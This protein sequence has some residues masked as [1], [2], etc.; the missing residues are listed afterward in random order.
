MFYKDLYSEI[1]FYEEFYTYSEAY[2][3]IYVSYY[4]R[5]EMLSIITELFYVNAPYILKYFENQIIQKGLKKKS[6]TT[7]NSLTNNLPPPHP[8]PSVV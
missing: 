3:H 7:N 6:Q 2:K 8:R 1:E 5:E 4:L